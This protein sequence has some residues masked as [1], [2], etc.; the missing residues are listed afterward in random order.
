MTFLQSFILWG[1]PLLLLPII[2]HLVN[3]MRHRTVP[4][5]AMRFLLKATQSSTS[6]AKLRQGPRGQ[7]QWID[8]RAEPDARREVDAADR[9]PQAG[10][11]LHVAEESN[12]RRSQ[13]QARQSS[14]DPER[15]VAGRRGRNPEQC[16]TED[17]LIGPVGHGTSLRRRL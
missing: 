17:G 11:G 3:R 10:I 1:L 13:R 8:A 14:H 16:R 15:Q 4:W 6:H 12:Q 9:V 7:Q 5:A 2:I